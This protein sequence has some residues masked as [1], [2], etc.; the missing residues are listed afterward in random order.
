MD[1]SIYTVLNMKGEIITSISNTL[2]SNITEIS[3]AINSSCTVAKR[4]QAAHISVVL[5]INTSINFRTRC[6]EV[7]AVSLQYK[8]RR[9]LY[10]GSDLLF[11]FC[12][13]IFC[14]PLKFFPA[15]AKLNAIN[16]G[17]KE[18]R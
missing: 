1:W 5:Q 16:G 4:V 7:R 17:N 10:E 11:P 13:A 3:R 9:P 2:E 6:P 18:P 12:S 15:C 8:R 14:K